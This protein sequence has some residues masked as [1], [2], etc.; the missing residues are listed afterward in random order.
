MT[1][2]ESVK[3]S[4][5]KL[6]MAVRAELEVIEGVS[7]P[8]HLVESFAIE[9]LER[10]SL[11]DQDAPTEAET[12]MQLEKAVDDACDNGGLTIRGFVQKTYVES[13]SMMA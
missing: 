7:P 2:S 8:A 12:A 5:A 4:V 10:F 1:P 13:R 11:E 3:T 9:F 6:R